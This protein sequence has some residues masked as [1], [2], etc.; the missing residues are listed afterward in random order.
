[1]A[2]AVGNG[3]AAIIR[4]EI[5][6]VKR[7]LPTTTE[8]VLLRVAQEALANVRKHAAAGRVDVELRYD[9]GAVA[10]TVRDDGRGFDPAAVSGGYGLRGM[11]E[12]IRQAGGTITVA[13]APGEGTVVRAEVPA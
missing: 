1:V 11:R 4:S 9:D 7:P 6:G 8:V 3:G 2:E 13:T 10:L 12:R 5:S